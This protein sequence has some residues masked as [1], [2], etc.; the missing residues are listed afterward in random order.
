[1]CQGQQEGAIQFHLSQLWK[2]I[3]FKTSNL[4]KSSD[5]QI[6]ENVP[7]W[8]SNFLS[9]TNNLEGFFFPPHHFISFLSIEM[10]HQMEQTMDI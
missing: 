3:E 5:K 8:E 10:Y 7:V 9:F 1:M 4:N 6:K 2:L